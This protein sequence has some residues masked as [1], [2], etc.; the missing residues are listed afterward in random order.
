MNSKD[1]LISKIYMENALRE[2]QKA[3]MNK[4]FKVQDSILLD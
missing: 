3:C 2:K 1:E 4:G